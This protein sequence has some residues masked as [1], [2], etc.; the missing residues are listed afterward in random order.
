MSAEVGCSAVARCSSAGRS[1][2]IL[3]ASR[4][5]GRT[6]TAFDTASLA[7]ERAAGSDEDDVDA[8]RARTSQSVHCPSA[9][10]RRCHE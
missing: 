10:A 4:S 6:K 5:T 9:E 7:V 2:S 1:A 8:R 3:P